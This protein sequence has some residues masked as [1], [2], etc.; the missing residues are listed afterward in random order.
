MWLNHRA[1]DNPISAGMPRLLQFN[2]YIRSTVTHWINQMCFFT[3][4]ATLFAITGGIWT[5]FA[6]AEKTDPKLKCK[7]NC[8]ISKISC[9][10]F[11]DAWSTIFIGMFDGLF[12]KRKSSIRFFFTSAATSIFFAVSM[13][14][15]WKTLYPKEFTYY[16]MQPWLSSRYY[17][18]IFF[19]LGN[20]V[21]DYISNCQTRYIIGKCTQ[22]SRN[23]RRLLAWIFLDFVLTSLI[24]L[25]FI[26]TL[27][28]FSYDFIVQ[29]AS[30]PVFGYSYSPKFSIY[31]FIT[32]HST[33]ILSRHGSM[34]DE[35]RRSLTPPYGLFFY[36][37]FLT[38][39]WLWLHNINTVI[40]VIANRF[41]GKK[42]K[43]FQSCK[44]KKTPLSWLGAISAA[45]LAAIYIF[46]TLLP[47]SIYIAFVSAAIWVLRKRHQRRNND[48]DHYDS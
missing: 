30:G 1:C 31:N 7:V 24:S 32:L 26:I 6:L 13:L 46:V 16:F 44:F 22:S 47:N 19:V 23:S 38:S 39:I 36:S 43:F 8:W 25:L 42:A 3:W 29:S 4:L 33:E 45:F 35:W 48:H 37:T 14:L 28:I 15:L 11:V 27:V 9:K 34:A 2:P 40:V 21:P 20:V 41:V 18:V 12:G 5:L 10:N 17:F